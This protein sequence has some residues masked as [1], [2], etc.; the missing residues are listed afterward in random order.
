LVKVLAQHKGRQNQQKN[1][2][3]LHGAIHITNMTPKPTIAVAM[4]TLT[5]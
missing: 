1:G 4:M 2:D 5:K 3:G